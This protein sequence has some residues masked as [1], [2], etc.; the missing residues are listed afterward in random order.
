M[1]LVVIFGLS[2]RVHKIALLRYVLT[3]ARHEKI[4]PSK[5]N[6]TVMIFKLT[7]PYFNRTADLYS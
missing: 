1:Q 3:A 2:Q 5:T 4:L 6:M 7:V